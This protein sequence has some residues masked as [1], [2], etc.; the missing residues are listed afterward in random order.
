MVKQSETTKGEVATMP[1][2]TGDMV[3]MSKELIAQWLA[4]DD[5]TLEDESPDI[6]LDDAIRILSAETADEVLKVNEMRKI[7][8]YDGKPFVVLSVTWRK[9]RKSD[10][11]QGR[12]AV[13][14]CVDADGAEFLTTC[15]ATKVVLQLRWAQ[16]HNA[17]PW[18]VQLE[19]TTTASGNTVKEL[20]PPSVDF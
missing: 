7:D 12:Y 16:L 1:D 18:R 13:M 15:G 17:L 9:S 8:T 3:P 11:G 5:L 4:G 20:V 2:S 14:R 10:D 19:V 6:D